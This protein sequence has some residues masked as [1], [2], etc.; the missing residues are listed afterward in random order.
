M[1]ACTL[2][3]VP[4]DELVEDREYYLI[5]TRGGLQHCAARDGN[6]IWRYAG[7]R[8]VE[9]TVTHYCRR[10]RSEAELAA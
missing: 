7:G 5:R 8:A 3:M 2:R 10:A 6:G 4:I 9:G 1:S